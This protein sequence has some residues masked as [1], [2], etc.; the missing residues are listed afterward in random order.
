MRLTRLI[1]RFA[2]L[3][4]AAA[5]AQ[6]AFALGGMYSGQL[7]PTGG[8]TPIPIVVE[9]QE[10]GTVLTGTVRT[11]EPMA[12]NAAIEYGRNMYG[13]CSFSVTLKPAGVL[14]LSGTCEPAAFRGDYNLRNPQGK[15]VARGSFSVQRKTADAA[16]GSGA[17]SAL[18]PTKATACITANARCLAACPRVDPDANAGADADAEANADAAFLCANRC[19]TRLQA[20]KGQTGKPAAVIE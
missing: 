4:F 14:R 5:C 3:L 13:Q 19:R 17:R 7:V 18:D 8:G 11:S 2:P 6:P 12:G 15:I 16:V 1:R 20:C 9:M 10:S